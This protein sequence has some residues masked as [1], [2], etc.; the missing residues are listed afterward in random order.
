MTP[1]RMKRACLF[2]MIALPAAA[3]MTTGTRAGDASIYDE[4]SSFCSGFTGEERYQCIR[5]C[6]NTKRRNEPP[7]GD[8]VKK[9]MNQCEEICKAYT[10]LEKIRCIRTCLDTNKPPRPQNK[11]I[12]TKKEDPCEARCGV[13]SG[14]LKDK[15]VLRC[16][17]DLKY[18]P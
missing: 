10:G 6:V 7:A 15:C 9:R 5:T 4:C 18:R 3:L 11:G 16:R 13:L 12:I 14:A 2:F 1:V 17:R 8:S